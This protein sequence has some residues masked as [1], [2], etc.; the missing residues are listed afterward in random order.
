M[1]GSLWAAT[2]DPDAPPR[3]GLHGRSSSEEEIG[4]E[5]LPTLGNRRNSMSLRRRSLGLLGALAIG[6]AACGGSASPTPA[7][8]TPAPGESA[9]PTTAPAT[10]ADFKFALDGEP[11]YFS[12]A[13]TDLPTS[14]IVGLLY[15]GL[16][17]INNKLESVP[18]L[19]ADYA[20]TS[21]DGLTWTLKLKQGVKFHDGSEVK[22]SDVVFSYKLGL[23]PNCTYIPDG[24]S[25]IQDNIATVEAPDDYT[26][27]FVLKQKFAPFAVTGLS[28]VVVPE[29][30][31]RDSFGRL[32]A[33]SGA[34][35]PA[36]VKALF[37]KI[38]A[39]TTA[40]A[41]GAEAPPAEC[42][43]AT[44]VTDL[45]ALLTKAG[46][47][48]PDKA[49]FVAEDGSTDNSAYGAE[50][51]SRLTDLN[52]TLAAKDVDQIA[53]SFRI[54]DFQRAPVGTGPYKLVKYTT[55]QSV[56]M[57][58]HDDYFGGPEGTKVG[59]A[60]VFIPII[61]DAAAAS[62]AL[63]K[64]D[65]NWQTEVTS[66]ALAALKADPNLQIAE[67]ADFGYYFIAFN[68]RADR[69]YGDL[70]LRTAFSMCI[71][72]EATVAA[73]TDGRGQPVQ[74]N[75]PPASWAYNPDV[76]PYKLDVEGAKK[77]IESSGWTLGADGIYAKDGKQLASE[78]YVRA[79]RPQRIAFGQ[80]ASDQL[81]KCGIGLTVKEGDFA[82]VLLPL[83]SYPNNFDTY[84][85]GWSTSID[86]DDFSIF[87]SS[88]C[89]TKENPDDN[90][91]VCWNNAEADKLLEDGRQELDQAKR[92]EIYA[93]FQLIAH[94]D[95]P[96]YFLW[97][98]LANAG[99]TKS[100]TS[101]T[102]GID[103]A[104]PLYY[105]NRDSWVVAAQ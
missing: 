57:A 59:P 99:V 88:K 60:R 85:G 46:V 11:T 100:V 14:W 102:S 84:L 95:L 79:G 35:D 56:E 54:L 66:D 63:Q 26:I 98:D 17:T 97:S 90:N 80:L 82:T 44:Y 67:Y 61:K 105:W 77:L 103:L 8:V 23:S 68:T 25:S 30:A 87:H 76:P 50:L 93:K 89:V 6:V 39:A 70:N 42:D 12:Y 24:C 52:T 48:L 43:Y 92:K 49:Q 28:V 101:T 9:A 45:E 32:Q 65:I 33:S 36:E 96:Y 16:Y 13:Y 53:A 4:A 86:P 72:H 69:L 7:P 1:R 73:A 2:A 78:M 19:A 18:D 81:K 38:D 20:E 91:F 3:A 5:E 62:A 31:V 55:A 74:A 21:A 41:C 47:Q 51:F 34:V 15:N 22:A 94:S 27:K 40:E 29:K 83:L 71:D 104:S 10:S 75:T 64:G 58:R 37:D